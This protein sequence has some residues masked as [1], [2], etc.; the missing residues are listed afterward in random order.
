[1]R[2]K[3][4]HELGAADGCLMCAAKRAEDAARAA[5]SVA[6]GVQRPAVTREVKA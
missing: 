1:M 5:S 4:T 2:Q 3:T 6:T